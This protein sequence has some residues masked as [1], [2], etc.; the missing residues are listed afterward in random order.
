MTADGQALEARAEVV[1]NF[2]A[3]EPVAMGS[4][5]SRLAARAACGALTERVPQAVGPEQFGLGRPAGI[6]MVHKAVSA[7]V[8]EDASR[9]VLAFDASNAFGTLPRQWVWEGVRAWIPELDGVARAWL[10]NSTTHLFWDAKGVAHP[11]V[12]SSGVDQECPLS[13]FFFSLGLA[14]SVDAISAQLRGLDGSL[15]EFS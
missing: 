2:F 8:D 12:A 7:R 11:C 9:V 15:K 5:V 4:V 14:A 1:V 10:R 13:L 6:E 3:G